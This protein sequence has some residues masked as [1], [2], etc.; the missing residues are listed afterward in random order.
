MTWWV[1]VNPGAGRR[2]E[3]VPRTRAALDHVGIDSALRVSEDADHIADLVAEGRAAGAR[4]F[5]SVG[6]DGTANLMV[7]GLLRDPWF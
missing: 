1:V 6:G 3:L 2:G 4:R 7:N 5:V